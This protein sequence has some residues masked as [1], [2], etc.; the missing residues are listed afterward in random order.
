MAGNLNLVPARVRNSDQDSTESERSRT[1]VKNQREI[2]IS[3]LA[4]LVW[5][6]GPGL[7][8]SFKNIAALCVVVITYFEHLVCWRDKLGCGT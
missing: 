6:V 4:D 8:A 2:Q 7:F 1:E 3:G 5:Q